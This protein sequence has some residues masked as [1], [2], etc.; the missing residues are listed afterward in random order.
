MKIS[1]PTFTR[2][3]ESARRSISKAF[4]EGSRIHFGGGNAITDDWHKCEK[5]KISFTIHENAESVCPL[6]KAAVNTIKK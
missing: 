6:C 4:I 1:R 2:I 5:C 3:Y